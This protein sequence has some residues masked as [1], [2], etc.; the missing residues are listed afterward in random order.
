MIDDDPT[1][2]ARRSFSTAQLL[3]LL[4]SAVVLLVLSVAI[5]ITWATLT[6]SVLA[7]EQERLIRGA[8][9]LSTVA[10]A[11][12]R[13]SQTRYLAVAHDSAVVAA[14]A[15]PSAASDAKSLT[16]VRA[17]LARLQTPTD[18]G[19]PVELWDASGHRVAFVGDD[20]RDSVG[21]HVHA[22]NEPLLPLAARP[23]LDSIVW[24]D[25]L[26]IGTLYHA[27]ARSFFWIAAPVVAGGKSLGIILQQRR[28]AA[29]PQA[30]QTLRELS[31]DSVSGYYRNVD[32]GTW[33][34]FGGA[35][36]TPPGI[37]PRDST[38]RSRESTGELIY[39]EQRVAGT[40]LVLGLEVPR[41]TV[42]AGAQSKVR[43]LGILAVVLTCVAGTLAWIVGQRVAKPLTRISGAAGEVAHGDY[44]AR[45][46]LTGTFEIATL[47][48]NF[49]H[50]A[51]QI[52]ESR[53]ALEAREEELRIMADAIPQLALMAS[54]DGRIL[55]LNERWYAYTGAAPDEHYERQWLDAQDRDTRAEVER[56]WR[57]GIASGSPFE[58]ET[59]LR[60]SSGELR[61][62]LTRVAP[63]HDREGTIT[64]WFGTSTDVQSLRDAREAAEAASRAKSDF[65]T[66]MSHELR[67]PLNAI[68]GYAELLELG[69]RGPISDEQRQDLARIRASQ[70][71]LLTLIGSVL[72][73][74]RIE[75]GR[76]HYAI[77]R[78]PVDALFASI[79]PLVAPQAAAK[80]QI[81]KFAPPE[82]SLA[83]S[84]DR[85]KVRQIVL[86]LLSNAIRHTP[87]GT[88][89]AVSGHVMSSDCV[90]ISVRD[91]GPGIPVDRREAVFEPFVQLDRTL[92]KPTEGI[93]LG[94]AISRDLAR[95]MAGDL[96]LQENSDA[97]ACFA[98]LLPLAH[99]T[100]ATQ[101]A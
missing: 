83:V 42:I 15:T 73:L 52:G 66:A 82:H 96:L 18:S 81:L 70:Q 90:E 20:L 43:Q 78:I 87:M 22:E 86:N 94:L 13:T 16:A 92:S 38:V 100:Q 67:T 25:S 35:P 12:V 27:G 50:M 41:A 14:L 10:A 69:I 40:P 46:P 55:W 45:V 72:D 101:H 26:Q 24:H 31:G 80:Q 39:A 65:L 37:S 63:V 88:T 95:G 91:N 59:H 48:D 21:L 61:W 49:N 23:G 29:N 75:R 4:T 30:Q 5:A 44:A 33:V 9:Q 58:M 51:K 3:S 99:P 76:V 11:G 84:A 60:A 77:E 34:T 79:E 1:S 93:G 98:L 6:R 47:A 97:G 36:A 32:G 85:D 53:A 74:S 54:P 8:R 28:I 56:Q 57:D 68:G 62:F 19:M 17:A 64:R 7:A 71:H 2:A 89:I